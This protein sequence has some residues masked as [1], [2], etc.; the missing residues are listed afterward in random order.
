MAYPRDLLQP[1][2]EVVLETRPHWLFLLGSV[3]MIAMSVVLFFVFAIFTPFWWIG[4]LVLAI[5]VLGALG[6]YLA[7]TN[8]EFV[9]TSERVIVRRGVFAK[10]GIEIPLDRITNI[11][12]NQSLTER[13]IGAGDL[14]IESAGENGTQ[15]FRDIKNP[16]QMQNLIYGQTERYE[17]SRT[18]PRR[19]DGMGGHRRDTPDFDQSNQSGHS[20]HSIPDQIEKLASLHERG[21]LS[22][23]EFHAKKQDLL[24]RM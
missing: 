3:V 14:T 7:W 16:A 17:D 11:S 8:I 9:V 6:Q 13:L 4:L 21:I 5:A 18:G 15:M 19:H 23:A 20:G 12:Y 2:E 10:R 22:D 24:D 1:N